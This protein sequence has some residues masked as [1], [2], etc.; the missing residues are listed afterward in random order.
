MASQ[1]FSPGYCQVSEILRNLILEGEY[2]L[3]GRIDSDRALAERFGV[4]RMTIGKAI[5]QLVD[6]GLLIRGRG[7]QG[8]LVCDTPRPV[9]VQEGTA[10][11]HV[12]LCFLDLYQ[13]THPYFSR[14]TRGLREHFSQA[15]R[16]FAVYVIH[17]SDLF[18]RRNVPLVRALA[19]GRI[20][21]LLLAG[22]ISIEDIYALRTS[23]VPHVWI[24]HELGGERIPAA[25][26]DYASGASVVVDHLL[27]L[28][29]RRI[30]L[31]LG[32]WRNRATELS[33][34]GYRLTLKLRGIEYDPQMIAQ[35]SFDEESGYRMALKV[36]KQK[37][38]P[39]AIFAVD[40]L[41][42][43][44]AMKAAYELNLRIPEDVSIVG[45]GNLVSPYATEPSLT[46]L[47]INLEK[48]V[49]AAAELLNKLC[50]G[51]IVEATHTI[52]SP[53]LIVRQSTGPARK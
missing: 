46:T 4:A 6:E 42:A 11:A 35:G 12:G 3:G 33:L 23:K 17:A 26:V 10:V 43:C 49:V 13:S 18:Y 25:L 48:M 5:K 30:A 22:K 27:E 20:R 2:K 16:P 47:E 40:D 41:I 52:F 34:M 15:N 32:H 7:R 50:S 37:P 28:G 29:H 39:T 51:S 24:N 1:L 9:C 21:G 8:T 14:L 53:E 44:G 45:C 38:R 31:L 36:L 19:E